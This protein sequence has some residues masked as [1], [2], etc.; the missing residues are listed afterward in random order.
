VAEAARLSVARVDIDVLR[1]LV[2]EIE[3]TAL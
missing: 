2:R 3:V 1:P